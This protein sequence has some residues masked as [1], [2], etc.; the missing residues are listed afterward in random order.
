MELEKRNAFSTNWGG[1]IVKVEGLTVWTPEERSWWRK[2]PTKPKT[3]IL[4]NVTDSIQN[5]EF[6]AILGPSG[7]GKTTYL[8]SLAGKC[9]LPSKGNVTVEGRNVSELPTGTVEILP[10][11]DVFMDC[12]SVMEHLVFMMEMK[13]GRSVKTA[14]KTILQTIM[15][16]LK[17]NAHERTFIRS[18]SGGER[19]LLSLASSLLSSPQILI[20]DEPTTDLFKEF[21]SICLMSEGKI[22]F[23]GT[24]QGC[25]ALFDSVD[26]RCPVNYNPAEFY[27]KAVSN[28]CGNVNHVERIL[29]NYR[30]RFRGC[31]PSYEGPTATP[32]PPIC[33]RTWP[34]QVQ[35]L[36]WRFSIRFRR[37]IKILAISL[38]LS[39]IIGAVVI[40]TCFAGSTGTTQTGVQN[41]RGFLWLICSEVSFSLSY[42]ALFSFESELPLFRREVG[43]YAVSAYYVARFLSEVPRCVIWPIPFVTITASAVELPNHFVTVLEIYFALLVTGLASTAYGLGMGALFISS[44]TMGDVMPCTDLPLFLMSG[45]FLR[46]SSLPVWLY[47]V[48]YISH[49][50]YAMDA[51]SNI[52]WRQI[53]EID[54]PLNTTNTCVK[55]GAA[56]L[57]ENGYSSNFVLQDTLG[58]LLVVTLWSILGYY[59]LKK[60]K[61][62]GYTY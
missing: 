11:F 56:V 24:H 16:A 2:K 12:L 34:K 36:L 4:N 10:Q 35:I 48:K 27:I 43:V 37:D 26:L 31:E 17:L 40:G 39:T 18:L 15:G 58:I 28:A 25:K 21:S 45:A 1:E 50:Y 7:A 47:P 33:R 22:L 3:V 46:I 44:G 62:K 5:G 32:R 55:N 29:E 57:M 14:N 52:Y 23:H 42:T 54:C 13:L 59:G 20:C 38:L 60:E 19:R 61:R 49:F 51:I 9:T 6:L 30:N 8:V 53:G 41:L